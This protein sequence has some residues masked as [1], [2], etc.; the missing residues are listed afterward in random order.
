MVTAKK[1]NYANATFNDVTDSFNNESATVKRIS[2]QKPTATGSYTYNGATQTLSLN[3]YNSSTMNI[4]GNTGKNA[5]SYTATVSLRDS[6]NYQW[7]DGSTSSINL[8]W[9]ISPKSVSV[10]W[11]SK[12]TFTYNGYSQAPTASASSGIYGET[13]ITRTTE[14][15]AGSYTSTASLSSVTGGQ[16]KTSN[17]TLTNTTKAFTITRAKTATAS[18]TNKTYNG[19]SQVAISGN[20]VRWSG[21]T[22]ATD[23]GT[24]YATATPTSNYAWSDGTTGSKSISWTINKKSVSV[25]W[26]STTTFT[27]NGYSQAPTASASSGIYGETLNITRTT[28]V[29]VYQV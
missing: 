8:S 10:T 26:G 22:S 3:G 11:E 21:T 4:S 29:Q 14:I 15:D 19:A 1:A 12:T 20:N 6:S 28:E 2:I 25:K 18:S 24:Y 7:S 13:N 9:R 5:G 17:Y 27:Y 23:A 16:G